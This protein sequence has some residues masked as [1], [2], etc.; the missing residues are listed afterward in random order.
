MPRSSRRR[1][2][3]LEVLSV[4]AI[5]EG[6]HFDRAFT[7]PS[8]IGHRALA[9]NLS[10]LAAMGR[11]PRLALLSLALPAC[12]PVAEFDE[13][14]AGLAA[15]AAQSRVTCGGRQPHPIDGPL[16]VDITVVGAVKRRQ[17]LTRGRCAAGRRPVCDR[18]R[19]ARR[20]PACRC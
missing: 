19:S 11:A 18:A 3:A 4:D 13:M 20:P 17:V 10:D 16:V 6:V 1:A 8:A 5:V 15:L 9:V 14:I 12:C 7:P 2:I